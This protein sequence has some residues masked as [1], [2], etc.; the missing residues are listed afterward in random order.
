MS[1]SPIIFTPPIKILHVVAG[2]TNISGGPA[3]SIPGLCTALVRAGC[4]ITLA[5][6]DGDV[7]DSVM[8]TQS[9]GVNLHFYCPNGS[10]SLAFSLDM[11]QHFSELAA[12]ADIIHVHELWLY[13]NW[14]AGRI[15]RRLGKPLIITPRGTLE[16]WSL[17]KSKWKKRL[18]ATL[19]TNANLRAAA[20]LH[21]T[22]PSEA[23]GFR[24]YGLTNPMA[25]IPNGVNI[26]TL[27]AGKYGKFYDKYPEC[28]NKR[29]MFFLSRIHS[30]KG[31][32]ELVKSWGELSRN[33]PDWHLVIAGPDYNNHLA[34]V[35][36]VISQCG[37]AGR[38]TYAGA[39]YG[40]EKNAALA[41]AELFVLPTYSENF[42]IAVAEALASGTPVITTHGAPWE[43]LQIHKCGWWI[44]IGIPPLTAALAEALALSPAQLGIMGLAGRNWVEQT[45]S[46][47][48]IASDML[49]VY[50]WMLRKGD[51]PKF[52]I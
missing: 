33:F 23:A 3:E 21:A 49:D 11:G 36:K 42:G 44:P 43:G 10:S 17:S 39:L 29:I 8:A 13:P 34:E 28:K 47:D 24:A 31:I 26:P 32:V 45:F 20:C 16:P 12:T 15:A 27:I 25:I 37:V 14:V 7:A 41:D 9:Q 4:H 6:L 22:A 1:T 46:W 51:P 38:T 19:F 30:K 50:L 18:V 35:K 5:M 52:V 48:A 2:L 40:T